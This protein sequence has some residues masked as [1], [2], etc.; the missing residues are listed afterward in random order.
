LFA[1]LINRWDNACGM[2]TEDDTRVTLDQFNRAIILCEY[3]FKAS[4]KQRLE[5]KHL[6]ETD[7]F[8]KW[9]RMV[10]ETASKGVFTVVEL[11]ESLG[12]LK[13]AVSIQTV[14]RWLDSNESPVIQGNKKGRA[15]TYIIK[16]K[17][18]D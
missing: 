18:V 12:G 2:L 3:F 13:D 16:P 7:S 4:I 11:H 6:S 15:Y 14:K 17:P 8:E 5:L 9:Q 1:L 10:L